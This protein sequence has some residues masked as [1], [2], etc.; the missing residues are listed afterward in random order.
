MQVP[1]MKIKSISVLLDKQLEMSQEN[2]LA[3]MHMDSE[4]PLT[5]ALL[6]CSPLLSQY[7]HMVI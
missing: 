4:M 2:A 3:K 6:L 5:A 1:Y 7:R